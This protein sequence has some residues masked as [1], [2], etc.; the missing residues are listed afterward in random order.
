MA[1][2]SF[3]LCLLHLHAFARYTAC[4]CSL[5]S[6]LLHTRIPIQ[7]NDTLAAL[8]NCLHNMFLVLRYTWLHLPLLHACNQLQKYLALSLPTVIGPS[9]LSLPTVITT[10]ITP[11]LPSSATLPMVVS[12]CTT[13]QCHPVT[14]SVTYVLPLSTNCHHKVVPTSL[15]HLGYGE[16]VT[17]VP[18]QQRTLPQVSFLVFCVCGGW[19]VRLGFL[20]SF[21]CC[22]CEGKL[23]QPPR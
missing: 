3:S 23:V 5:P 22:R 6:P 21:F 2:L 17:L 16:S 20:M 18:T 9:A 12:Y 19:V 11:S 13:Y 7:H 8:A 1:A 14:S 10:V 15:N 4:A